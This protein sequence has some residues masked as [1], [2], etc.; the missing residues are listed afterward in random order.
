MHKKDW[1]MGH[2]KSL[3]EEQ[4]N[5]SD[6]NASESADVMTISRDAATN[7]VKHKSHHNKAR[8]VAL[9]NQSYSRSRSSRDSSSKKSSA[10][11]VPIA[12]PSSSNPRTRRTAAVPSVG[13]LQSQ[14]RSSRNTSKSEPPVT[15]ANKRRDRSAPRS[16][17][18]SSKHAP[19]SGESEYSSSSSRPM[20]SA[21]RRV[22]SYEDDPE[23]LDDFVDE[24]QEQSQDGFE[25]HSESR[26]PSKRHDSTVS[27][28][29]GSDSESSVRR[30]PRKSSLLSNLNGKAANG[31]ITPSHVTANA[32]GTAT[33]TPKRSTR[34][35]RSR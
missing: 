15:P 21:S 2:L 30:S 4:A 35:R 6:S 27:R 24:E 33:L 32:N 11:N 1:E 25:D 17:N 29:R 19:G 31:L 28:S 14:I 13:A 34:S 20:R 8:I 5:N 10:R 12:S 18:R 26:T 3:K 7:Q 9:Q 16:E 23:Y 22:V